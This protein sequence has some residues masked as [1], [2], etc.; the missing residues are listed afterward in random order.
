MTYD[1]MK[2][3]V[4]SWQRFRFST[5]VSA[6]SQDQSR[7]SNKQSEYHTQPTLLECRE[8]KLI[9]IATCSN[10]LQCPVASQSHDQDTVLLKGAACIYQGITWVASLL[11]TKEALRRIFQGIS[12]PINEFKVS[13]NYLWTHRFWAELLE[14]I[15]S[16]RARSLELI[17]SY[18]PR[19]CQSRVWQ[20]NHQVQTTSGFWESRDAGWDA[21]LL[22]SSQHEDLTWDVTLPS[23]TNLCN[24]I[25]SKIVKQRVCQDQGYFQ[26]SSLVAT[27][28]K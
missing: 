15:H 1:F 25:V 24:Q 22:P 23:C 14:A 2:Q 5:L 26:P 16:G 8:N 7:L 20:Q 9:R 3:S 12:K 21:V 18:S 13:L 4:P 19:Q 6:E 28:T 17:F 11:R 10:Y 27:E